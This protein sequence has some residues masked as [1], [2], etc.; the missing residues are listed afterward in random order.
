[1]SRIVST[2]EGVETMSIRVVAKEDLDSRT[3]VFYL[4][5]NEPR[6]QQLYMAVI[7]GLSIDT[8]TVYNVKTDKFEEVT[9]LFQPSFLTDLYQQLS[10]QLISQNQ[11]KAL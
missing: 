7:E 4:N 6:Q 11:A 5:Q 8:L 9:A 1:M 10:N 3:K 2:N